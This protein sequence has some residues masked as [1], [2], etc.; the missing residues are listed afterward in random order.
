MEK[1]LNELVQR[2]QKAHGEG[3][4]SIILYGSAAAGDYH[5]KK[6]DLNVLC[7]LQRVG[8]EELA[9][10]QP[11]V[12]WWREQGNPSPVLLSAEEVGRSADSFPLEFRDLLDCRRVLFGADVIAGLTVDETT[13]R[14]LVEHEL[15]A[16]L[17]RLRQKAAGILDDRELLLRLM[18]DSLPTFCVLARHAVRLAGGEAPATKRAAIE[19]AV[20]HFSIGGQAFYTLLDLRDGVLKPK[21]VDPRALFAQY[22]R[23]IDGLV[24]AVDRILH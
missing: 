6:S 15:R 8:V 20:E 22:L 5:G 17:L 24:R 14:V 9:V 13:Y 4:V 12:T 10:D 23:E 2:M 21:T 16:K 19:R 18:N 3:L 7:V 11:I 1:L